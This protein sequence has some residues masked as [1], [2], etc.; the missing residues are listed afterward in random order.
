MASRTGR[1]TVMGRIAV[2]I[3]MAVLAGPAGADVGDPK[4]SPMTFE[5]AHYWISPSEDKA[6]DVYRRAWTK[7]GDRWIDTRSKNSTESFKMVIDRM[8]NGYPPTAMHWNAQGGRKT[9]LEA[10]VL[11]YIDDVAAEQRWNAILPEFVWDAITFRGH[12]FLAPTNIHALNWMWTSRKI[13]DALGLTPPSSWDEV[14]STAQKIASAGYQPIA[15]GSGDWE[16]GVLFD[17]IL[18]GFYGRNGY[19]RVMKD[20]DPQAI[21]DE[22]VLTAL[23][24]LRSLKPFISRERADPSWAAAARAVGAGVAGMQ[25]TGDWAKGELLASGHALDRDFQCTPAPGTDQS[26]VLVLDAIAFPLTSRDE[27]REAQGKFAR[28]VLDIGNQTEFNAIKG[29]VPVRTDIPPDRLDHC[30]R[31]EAAQIKEPNHV[32]PARPMF[33]PTHLSVGWNTVLAHYFNS[34]SMTAEEAQKALYD[35][36]LQN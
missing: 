36:L 4:S 21:L 2:S 9:L 16:I 32:L 17:S 35:L 20:V 25:F 1:R 13:F 28:Q 14:L 22:R 18:A 10:G 34:G 15:M 12:V 5:L 3:L 23:R 7:S 11:R 31:I 33:M 26:F 6:L 29:A 24:V 30:A 8:A 19:L 27:D